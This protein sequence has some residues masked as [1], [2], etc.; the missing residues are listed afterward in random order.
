MSPQPESTKQLPAKTFLPDCN[1]SPDDYLLAC[2][3][4]LQRM[5]AAMFPCVIYEDSKGNIIKSPKEPGWRHVK[6]NPHLNPKHLGKI[7]GIT[8]QDDEVVIDSD[9]RRFRENHHE[10]KELWKRLSL[11]EPNFIVKTR[12]GFHFYYSKT[13]ELLLRTYIPETGATP[14][15]CIE[16]KTCRNFIIGPGSRYPDELGGFQ[17]RILKAELN[18]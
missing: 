7:F 17:Y 9:F 10:S 14:N 15:T 2:I 3:E 5:K 8:L 16:L 11:P 12:G 6:Y 13:N 4:L 18:L 1:L